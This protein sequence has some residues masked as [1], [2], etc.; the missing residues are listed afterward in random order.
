MKRQTRRRAPARRRRQAL[1][2]GEPHVGELACVRSFAI[3][4]RIFLVDLF[5]LS[6]GGGI[7][8]L[9]RRALGDE[10]HGIDGNC[11]LHHR[12][13]SRAYDV[14]AFL[15]S[16]PAWRSRQPVWSGRWR[17]HV[18][19]APYRPGLPFQPLQTRFCRARHPPANRGAFSPSDRR[20]LPE[21]PPARDRKSEEERSPLDRSV[22]SA[23]PAGRQCIPLGADGRRECVDDRHRNRIAARRAA[24]STESVAVTSAR[25]LF[26]AAT[27]GDESVF[28]SSCAATASAFREALRGTTTKAISAAINT[29]PP[30]MPNTTTR[31]SAFLARAAIQR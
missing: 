11:G 15:L 17:W 26:L 30:T 31:R 19:S 1:P 7:V 4:A 2:T 23:L 27:A 10:L 24:F 6:R 5:S 8:L 29:T 13:W 14:R 16:R 3:D 22:D 20:Q 28:A 12:G 25:Y 9:R 21:R 18:R